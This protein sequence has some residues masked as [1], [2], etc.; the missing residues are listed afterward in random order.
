MLE[1]VLYEHP[2]IEQCAVVGKKDDM[3]G[4]IPVAFVA[5]REGAKATPE[6]LLDFVN[7]KVAAYKKVRELRFIDK[8]PLNAN[9]KVMRRELTALL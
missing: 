6:K 3:A 4:E 2:S 7:G 5:L 9:G 8:I 1:D